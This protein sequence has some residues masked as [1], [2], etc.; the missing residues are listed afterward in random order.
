[1]AKMRIIG[2]T[3]TIESS[4]TVAELQKLS[5]FNPEALKLRDENNDVY[6]VVATGGIS[7]IGKHGI[8]FA[9]DSY[10]SEP[11]ATIEIS[12]S[13]E[14]QDNPKQYAA[15][16]YGSIF[17]NLQKVEEG[18]AEAIESVEADHQAIVAA[19]EG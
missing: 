12:L 5:K 10:T 18:L 2:R 8:C 17:K 19:I 3:L 1:M 15:E 16:N 7:S 14:A 9:G 13:L 11:K 6:F 4:A